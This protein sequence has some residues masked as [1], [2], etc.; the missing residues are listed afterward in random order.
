MHFGLIF[1]SLL[2]VHSRMF[3][4]ITQYLNN[5]PHMLLLYHNVC[6]SVNALYNEESLN[7]VVDVFNFNHI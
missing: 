5:I 1:P 7:F 3:K 4:T 2:E 6:F